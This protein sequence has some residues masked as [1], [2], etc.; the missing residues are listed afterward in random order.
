MWFSLRPLEG[1]HGAG[2][3]GRGGERVRSVN[4]DFEAWMQETFARGNREIIF[5][6]HH[7]IIATDLGR[8]VCLTGEQA[9]A[10]AD[11]IRR[12]ASEGP[13][14]IQDAKTP[15]ATEDQ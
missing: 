1:L 6:G 7:V 11:H 15:D 9:L 5:P 12:L 14:E 4:A 2:K 3:A 13:A 10:L 8:S